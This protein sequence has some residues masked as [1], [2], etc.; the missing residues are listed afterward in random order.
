MQ[1]AGPDRIERVRA[2]RD[3]LDAALKA[4]ETGR[5]RLE[6]LPSADDVVPTASDRHIQTIILP[7]PEVAAIVARNS[8]ARDEL[9]RET[10]LKRAVAIAL[11]IGAAIGGLVL[12]LSR[13]IKAFLPAFLAAFIGLLI[14]GCAPGAVRAQA[15][16]A[17]AAQA[18]VGG[19][20]GRVENNPQATVEQPTSQPA[21][22][23]T[24]QEAGDRARQYNATF[25]VSGSAWPIA[26]M[27][28]A[29]AVCA[30][31]WARSSGRRRQAEGAAIISGRR[32]ELD[33]QDRAE[34]ESRLVKVAQSVKAMPQGAARDALLARVRDRLTPLERA[35]FD[36]F[37]KG[38]GLYVSRQKHGSD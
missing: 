27:A 24:R 17:V 25:T 18:N 8:Q 15:D 30:W 31:A 11:E 1:Q 9:E 22:S 35:R 37:L 21:R 32:A 23:E 29:L 34:A 6:D 12:P 26:V 14:A 10:A 2:A 38:H 4:V 36:D 7:S 19:L 5:V 16:A 28:A 33:R 3:L 20:V 13:M